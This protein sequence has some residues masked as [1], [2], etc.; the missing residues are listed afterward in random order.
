MD[1]VHVGRLMSSPVQT[2]TPDQSVK[3]AA[4]KMHDHDINSVVVV[5]DDNRL[6]GILTSTDYVYMAADD[7]PAGDTPVSEYMTGAVTTTTVNDRVNDVAETMMENGVH[8]VPVVD[9]TEGVVG[10]ITTKDFTA[11]L[12]DERSPS[13]PGTRERV[14]D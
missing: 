10:M 3:E 6:Q 5:D 1:D 9:D 4:Q 12:S 14:S 2:V 7:A 13:P 8:H 11:Y